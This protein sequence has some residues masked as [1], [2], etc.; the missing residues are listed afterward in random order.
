MQLELPVAKVIAKT[1]FTV[2]CSNFP[3][4]SVSVI[5]DISYPSAELFCAS[6]F[7]FQLE[8]TN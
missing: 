6:S 4:N 1:E 3:N 5:L 2:K 8:N 7:H